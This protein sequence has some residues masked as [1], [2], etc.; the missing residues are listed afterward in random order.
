MDAFDSRD[1]AAGVERDHDQQ[2]ERGIYDVCLGHHGRPGHDLYDGFQRAAHRRDWCGL[3]AIG[4]EFAAVEFR[5]TAWSSGIARDLHRG[6][7]G[8][9]GGAGIVVPGRLAAAR[10]VGEG[11]SRGGAVAGGNDPNPDCGGID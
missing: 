10:F 4:D 7:S 8:V 6:R 1:Q 5:G 3:L 2:Y 11:W 9:S